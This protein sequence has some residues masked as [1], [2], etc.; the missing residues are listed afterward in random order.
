MPEPAETSQSADKCSITRELMKNVSW[1][2]MVIDPRHG[3]R[4][5]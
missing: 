3:Y 4:L 5:R 1:L 2:L